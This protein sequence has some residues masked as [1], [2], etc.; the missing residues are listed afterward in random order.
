[1]HSIAFFLVLN[2]KERIGSRVHLLN[3]L[4][5][6]TQG[7]QHLRG[8]KGFKPCCFCLLYSMVL[9]RSS[10]AAKPLIA[11]HQSGW[12]VVRGEKETEELITLYK[13]KREEAQA[14]KRKREQLEIEDKELDI[15][16]KRARIEA[17]NIANKNAAYM[18][19]MPLDADTRLAL[20][21]ML[22]NA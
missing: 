22:K 20:M 10:T 16:E 7:R 3:M 8:Q 1:M 12:P 4:K 21:H 5:T 15:L 19:A 9:T 13:Q 6:H 14:T 2:K 11:S 18:Q 17:M